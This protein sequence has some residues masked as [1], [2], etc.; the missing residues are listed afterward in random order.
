MN[1]HAWMLFACACTTWMSTS[2][3]F[4]PDVMLPPSSNARA[5]V[6]AGLA[7]TS[8]F[9]EPNPTPNTIPIYRSTKPDRPYRELGVVFVNNTTDK[10]AMAASLRQV[11]A[12]LGGDALI[13]ADAVL[14][15]L[16]A[17]VVKWEDTP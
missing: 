9:P 13:E 3:A 15:G 16:V 7:F 8:G 11:A 10:T 6:Q 2:C 17:T 1:R 4:V 5:Y 14:G 12:S